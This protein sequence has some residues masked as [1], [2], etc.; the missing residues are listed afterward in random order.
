MVMELALA[1]V[2]RFDTLAPRIG[3][4]WL[5]WDVFASS[6]GRGLLACLVFPFYDT[7]TTYLIPQLNI[8]DHIQASSIIPRKPQSRPITPGAVIEMCGA[9]LSVRFDGFLP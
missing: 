4:T 6:I 8:N 5:G 9:P 7:L 3:R 1:G 2:L